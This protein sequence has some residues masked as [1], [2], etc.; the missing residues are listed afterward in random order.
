MDPHAPFGEN[1]WSEL[2]VRLQGATAVP[3]EVASVLKRESNHP[4]LSTGSCWWSWHSS[5]LKQRAESVG[6]GARG[7]EGDGGLVVPPVAVHPP[8]F[9][10]LQGRPGLAIWYCIGVKFG[11]LFATA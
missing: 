3:R 10:T 11:P 7:A 2:E 6:P 5:R 8:F 1:L 4:I 9:V